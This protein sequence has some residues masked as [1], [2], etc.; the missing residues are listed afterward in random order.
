[1]AIVFLK[2]VLGYLVDR[3]INNKFIRNKILVCSKDIDYLSA[4]PFIRGKSSLVEK[5]ILTVV[6]YL[7][8]NCG[9][10]TSSQIDG[11]SSTVC[12]RIYTG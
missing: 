1:M 3:T 7:T 2:A 12:S 9:R 8:W 11:S 6:L 5:Y 4:M 10:G